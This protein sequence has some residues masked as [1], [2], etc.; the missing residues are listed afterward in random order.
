MKRLQLAILGLALLL[1]APARATQL[2]G[3]GGG[4][5]TNAGTAGQMVQYSAPT[6][7]SGVSGSTM[8]VANDG[9]TGTA[10]NKLAKYTAAGNAVITAAGDT[11]G[12]I[13]I[14]S[15][16]AG[17]TGNAV[18][19]LSGLISCVFDGA[20][21]ALDYVQI[22]GSV[23]GDCHDAGAS[24]PGSGQ[25][26]GRVLST[27]ASGGTY[28][29]HLYPP[30]IRMPANPIFST[31]ATNAGSGSSPGVQSIVPAANDLAFGSYISGDANWRF[32]EVPGI[33]IQI[34]NA[35]SPPATFVDE[36]RNFSGSGANLTSLNASNISSGTLPNARISGW[37][38]SPAFNLWTCNGGQGQLLT[39]NTLL[40]IG[41]TLPAPVTFSNLVIGVTTGDGTNNSDVGIYNSAGTLIADAGAQHFSTTGNT[42]KIAMVQG[43]QTIQPGK[44]YLAYTSTA[45]TFKP[46]VCYG[47]GDITFA[48]NASFGASS[49]GALPASITPPAEA[50]NTAAPWLGFD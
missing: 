38:L 34:G 23:A 42:V 50:L 10:A 4:V 41:F 24:Y 35:S 26:L 13:G 36:S 18:V 7:L 46:N 17:I 40:L 8:P 31:V 45:T 39:A 12:A 32:L 43:S 19:Q 48:Y 27:N 25:V 14:V 22:S 9:T 49:G 11:G 33:G 16:G 28:A 20:T 1:A 44:Y 2:F 47:G 6:T 29:M 15:S 37:P 21:T 30:E 3:A 5:S